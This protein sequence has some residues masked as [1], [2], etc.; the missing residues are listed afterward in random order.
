MVR[1]RSRSRGTLDDGAYDVVMP[2]LEDQPARDRVAVRAALESSYGL[3]LFRGALDGPPARAVL[4]L[5]TR[6]TAP[7]P[8]AVAV[9]RAYS[10]AFTALAEARGDLAAT[11]PDAW[12][13]YLVDALLDEVNP[14]SRA[15]ERAGDAAPPPGLRAQAERDLRALRLLFNLDADT[16][17]RLTVATVTPA[18]PA[19]ADA[20]TPWRDLAPPR[21]T[22]QAP[23]ETAPRDA[24]IRQV[25]ETADW[26]RLVAP[27]TAYWS[28]HGA[29]PLA[30][31]HALRWEGR[32]EG[33]RGI[34]HPDGVRLDA[35]VA[36]ER[37]QALL[38]DNL[39]R[40]LA[41]LP[42]HDALLYGAP[43]TGK[44]S[45]VK[46]LANTYADR[47]LCLVEARKEDL[48]DLPAILALLRDHARAYVLFIDDLSF[49]DDETEYKA[50]K[51][52][53]EGTAERRPANVLVHATTNRLNLIRERFSERGKPADDVQW[54]DTMDE[55]A[56]LAERFG[57]RV[58]FALPDQ[59]RYLTIATA[60]AR[61]RGLTLPEDSLRARALSWQRQHTGRSG[62]LARQFVDE[63]QGEVVP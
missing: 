30:R 3:T 29:G 18:L 34:A 31:Y 51:V 41:G 53:L 57:L 62:R 36:Y 33:L 32:A 48:G 56:S 47:G 54:R 26:A 38:T 15:A 60:L 19:L 59:E 23:S 45:T 61:Q 28:R 40:F 44:S 58:T 63:L 7:E 49:E 2:M 21:Q 42:A 24:F 22:R 9:A 6:L 14:L 25:E 1:R 10:E 50:L 11:L 5:L 35:L 13:A 4:A 46:A 43:G 8:D 12:Q 16:M 37:E 52:L 55:K 27:L 20:W 39:E 17:W